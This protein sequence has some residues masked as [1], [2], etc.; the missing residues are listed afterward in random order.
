MEPPH[1]PLT[2]SMLTRVR[3]EYSESSKV[4]TL[5]FAALPRKRMATG[6]RTET[7][8][9]SDATTDRFDPDSAFVSTKDSEIN[10]AEVTP[11]KDDSESHKVPS[12]VAH[13]DPQK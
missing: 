12:L 9:S 8:T 4:N 13:D 6:T 3:H 5:R 1:R 11:C 10:L 2:D 7:E